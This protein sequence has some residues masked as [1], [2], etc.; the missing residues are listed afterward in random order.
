MRHTLRVSVAILILLESF[1]QFIYDI[2]E[3]VFTIMSQSLFYWNPFY[4]KVTD[5][6]KRS[7]DLSRNPYF[8]GILSTISKS[9]RGCKYL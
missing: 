2:I 9:S 7:Q 4:N 6:I 5:N 1:L 8:I 3:Y